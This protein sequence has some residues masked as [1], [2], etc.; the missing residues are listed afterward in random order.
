MLMPDTKNGFSRGAAA[1]RLSPAIAL[2]LVLIGAAGGQPACQHLV[3]IDS[4]PSGPVHPD[5]RVDILGD[6]VGRDAADVAQ[7]RH[8]DD[9]ARP[10]PEGSTPAVLAGLDHP[11]E[12]C[13]LVVHLG[14]CSSEACRWARQRV[15]LERGGCRNPA[16]SG[17]AQSPDRR[18]VAERVGE[19]SGVATWSASRTTMKSAV[20]ISS[21]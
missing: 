15:M 6:R 10:A 17:R 2:E 19:E 13:L 14:R 16:G 18:E 20:D 11:I 12:Q 7:R 3:V 8:P 21:A 9:R 1:S 4:L 5:R